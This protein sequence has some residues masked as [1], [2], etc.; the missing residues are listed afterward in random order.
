MA[1]FGIEN[2]NYNKENIVILQKILGVK[3]DGIYGPK[4]KEAVIKFQKENG[5]V[6]DGIVGPKTWGVLLSKYNIDS[7]NNK[8]VSPISNSESNEDYDEVDLNINENNQ[9]ETNKL[10]N[11]INLLVNII[12]NEKITRR[13]NELFIHCTDTRLDTSVQNILNIFKNVYKWK[14]PGYHILIKPDGSFSYI[15]NLNLPSNGVANRNSNSIHVSWIGGREI[16]NNKSVNV[17]N[18]TDQQKMMLNVI[19]VEFI[20]RFPNIKI[21]GH[22][23][24]SNKLCPLF[25]VKKWLNNIGVNNKNI[26]EA[27]MFGYAKKLDSI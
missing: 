23:Q 25:S 15:H 11:D 18:I 8:V 2:N 5:L 24:V 19:V 1:L 16:V 6:A 22:N 9:T 13:I 10:S 27:D 21:Y 26:G 3:P 20:K 12:R 17:L 4:T 7:N 14:S